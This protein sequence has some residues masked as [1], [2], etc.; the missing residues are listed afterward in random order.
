[1]KIVFKEK[2]GTIEVTIFAETK[3]K[4]LDE[5]DEVTDNN[6]SKYSILSIELEE[7]QEEFNIQAIL[8]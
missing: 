2:Q 5:L 1:M 3:E 6:S 8:F 7:K 4:A